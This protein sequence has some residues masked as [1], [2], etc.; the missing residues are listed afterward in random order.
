MKNLILLTAESITLVDIFVWIICAIVLALMVLYVRK[1]RMEKGNKEALDKFLKDISDVV[2]KRIIEFIN[3]FDITTYKNDYMSLQSDLLDGLY[4]DIYEL[5]MRELESIMDNDSV[6]LALLKKSL[7][8]EKIEDYVSLMMQEEPL[9]DKF[10]NV[11]NSVLEKENKRIEAEDKALEK[12]LEEY[13]NESD[14]PME[15]KVAELDPRVTIDPEKSVIEEVI[16]PPREEEEETISADDE[17]VEI[18]GDVPEEQI[19]S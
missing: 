2:R 1:E 5:S 4:N 11:V 16:N 10:T 15:S 19:I 7:T 14:D 9:M 18:V 13:E 12:E 8:K 6:T 17:S 3:D